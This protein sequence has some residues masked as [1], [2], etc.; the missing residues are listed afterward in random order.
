MLALATKTDDV[1][2]PLFISSFN[3]QLCELHVVLPSF[4]P[5]FALV[6]PIV[7]PRL[8][9]LR[10]EGLGSCPR[11]HSTQVTEP[12]VLTC[13][14]STSFTKQERHWEDTTL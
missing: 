3:S 13:H 5:S 12:L 7:W 4:C 10:P 9:K 1:P 11:A 14:F 8:G 6:L 2:S